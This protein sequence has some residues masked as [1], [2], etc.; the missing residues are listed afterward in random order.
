[1]HVDPYVMCVSEPGNQNDGRRSFALHARSVLARRIS[2]GWCSSGEAQSAE[3]R[4]PEATRTGNQL[5]D[6]RA[7][8]C[9]L[10]TPFAE[11]L[12]IVRQ[13]AVAAFAEARTCPCHHFA[14]IEAW[15]IIS[16]PDAAAVREI[17]ER[18]VF[19]RSA[20]Q[21]VARPSVMNDATIADVDTVMAVERARGDETRG[22]R[23]FFVHT[24]ERIA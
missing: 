18:N 5:L 12:A 19:H 17:F 11:V 16:N 7:A 13:D 14:T 6:L 9:A 10:Q 3:Q 21:S 24:E 22:E 23:G 1:M 20:A 15:S 2:K 4:T 8:A